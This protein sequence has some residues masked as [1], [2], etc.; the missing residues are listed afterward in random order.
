MGIS[1]GKIQLYTAA[2]GVNPAHCLPI[3]LDVGTNNAALLADPRYKGL[4]QPRI[5]GEE[6]D[7]FVEEFMTALQD[8]QRHMLLQF[9]DVGNSN[10]FS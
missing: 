8:W 10:A 9:E 2:A 5:V 6:Y 4:Q 1:E 3:C 7:E